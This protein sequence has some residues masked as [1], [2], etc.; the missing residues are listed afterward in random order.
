MGEALDCEL[1]EYDNVPEHKFSFRHRLAMKRI[2]SVSNSSHNSSEI[3]K[4]AQNCSLKRSIIIAAVLVFL[5]VIAGAVVMFRS[6]NFG[7]T[8]HREYTKMFAVNIEDSPKTI[9]CKYDLAYV[10]EGFELYEKDSSS[11]DVYTVYMNKSTKQ[12]IVLSQW[13][14]KSFEPHYNTEHRPL[15]EVVINGSAGFCIDFSRDTRN[16]SLIV[17]D[18]GDYIIEVVADLDKENTMKLCK[19]NKL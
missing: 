4:T 18:N 14:K 9:G 10:P 5:A 11:F 8:V 12:T 2:I 7:G 1:A 15:E 3:C 6:D 13:V 17:W 16:H 19:I